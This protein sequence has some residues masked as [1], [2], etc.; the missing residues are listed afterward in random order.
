M[1][2]PLGVFYFI[3]KVHFNKKGKEEKVLTSKRMYYTICSQGG[4]NIKL[5][6]ATFNIQNKY[7][8][9]GYSGIDSYGDHT[10]ELV[11]FISNNNIDIIGLQELTIN[12]K[13]R[14]LK[15]IC[16]KYKVVG[17]YRFTR[18]G[19][20]IPYIK[21][22]NESNSII[23][24]K[25][26]IKSKTIHIPFSGGIPR[27]LTIAYIL[28]DNYKIRVINTHLE[29]RSQKSRVRQLKYI[30]KLL[31]K[32]DMYTILMGDFNTITN[33]STFDTFITKLNDL[34]YQRVEMN[35]PTH[36]IKELPIDHIFIPK[37]WKVVNIK[38]PKI[39]SKMSDHKPIIVE[40][41]I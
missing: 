38:T 5:T 37:D 1:K 41:S 15:K 4:D 34:R 24:N 9:K 30:E 26:I 23:T 13:K 21:K 33:D 29:N 3:R 18:I 36:R 8:V 20:I 39:N 40:V 35:K 27:I 22:Y 31:N 12:Y 7:K 11:E 28:I 10:K 17:K 14:L 19:N 16:N 2:T 6:I 25:K 32:E